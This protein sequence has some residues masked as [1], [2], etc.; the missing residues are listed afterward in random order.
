MVTKYLRLRLLKLEFISLFLII[1]SFYIGGC[2]NIKT[3]Y[4]SIELSLSSKAL[5]FDSIIL[6]SDKS[7]K[8]CYDHINSLENKS[9]IIILFVSKNRS[10]QNIFSQFE[11]IIYHNDF[12]ILNDVGN[13]IKNFKEPYLIK[14][15]NGK[16]IDIL[17]LDDS[18]NS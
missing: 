10:E 17:S 5:E 9:K 4:D 1:L 13:A 6:V 15:E 11:N 12:S 8:M 14:V 16:I 7:C 2:N 18:N 3:Q